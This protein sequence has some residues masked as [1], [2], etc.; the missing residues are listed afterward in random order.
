MCL[1]TFTGGSHGRAGWVELLT[2]KISAVK[3]IAPGNQNISSVRCH[4]SKINLMWPIK[5][6][7]K[8]KPSER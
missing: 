5:V 4:F 7:G 3:I 6:M 1:K 8:G 2:E